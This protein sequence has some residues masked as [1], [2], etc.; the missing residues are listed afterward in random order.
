MSGGPEGTCS[1]CNTVQWFRAWAL[2]SGLNLGSI[3]PKLCGLGQSL[4][5]AASFVQRGVIIQPSPCHT[6]RHIVSARK[7]LS[8]FSS[9][10][11][12]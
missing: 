7:L 9:P 4:T 5:S 1:K 8:V 6:G 12:H 11:T 3:I 2:E 10:S